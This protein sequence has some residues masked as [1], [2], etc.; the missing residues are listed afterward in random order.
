VEPSARRPHLRE[1]QKRSRRDGA[2]SNLMVLREGLEQGTFGAAPQL[3]ARGVS[4][5]ECRCEGTRSESD[6]QRLSRKHRKPL[7]V[8]GAVQLAR[9]ARE[10]HNQP[11]SRLIGTEDEWMILSGE[12]H[13]F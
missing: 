1:D 4:D 10:R 6:L 9:A 8:A 5:D 3:P 7:T 13:K 11:R 12:F 2:E